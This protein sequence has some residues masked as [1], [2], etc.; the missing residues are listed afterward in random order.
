MCLLCK[1][2]LDVLK[3]LIPVGSAREINLANQLVEIARYFR[4]KSEPLSEERMLERNRAR[5]QCQARVAAISFAIFLITDDRMAD[6][7][8]MDANLVFPAGH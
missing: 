6:P 2:P 5:M 3:L 8:Q 7:C 4:L 1:R